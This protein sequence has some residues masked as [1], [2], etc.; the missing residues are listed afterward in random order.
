MS[1]RNSLIS[2]DIFSLK[3]QVA[4]VTGGY[5]TLGGKMALGLAR[6]GAMV[7]VLGRDNSKAIREVQSIKDQGGIAMAIAADVLDESQLQEALA[8]VIKTWGKL[9]ILVNAAG[10]NMPGALVAPDQRVWEIST[11]DLRKVLDLNQLGTILPSLTFAR[12]FEQSSSGVIVNISSMA[13]QKAI[14]RVMGY[15]AAKAAVD[16]FTKW[17]AVEMAHKFGD[18]IRVNAIAPGFF[19]GNQNRDLLLNADGSLTDRGGDIIEITPMGRF[20]EPEE[21]VGTLIWLCSPASKFVTGTVI[22][23]DGGF[24]AFGGV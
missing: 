18:G 10:G 8:A 1:D 9:D 2:P 15:S 16:N 4:V 17:M 11:S 14:T 19:I 24:S 6:F 21:L 22:P 7:G 12:A 20:G 13:S 23:V 5:G 3:G